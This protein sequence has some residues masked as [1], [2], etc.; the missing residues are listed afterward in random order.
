[1]NHFAFIPAMPSAQNVSSRLN[2]LLEQRIN[3]LTLSMNLRTARS[4]SERALQVISDQYKKYNTTN[5][6]NQKT[7]FKIHLVKTDS[8]FIATILAEFAKIEILTEK[9][10]NEHRSDARDHLSHKPTGSHNDELNASIIHLGNIKDQNKEK[11]FRKS[12]FYQTVVHESLHSKGGLPDN[13]SYSIDWLNEAITERLTT[14][15]IQKSPELLKLI[16]NKWSEAYHGDTAI[17]QYL[18]DFVGKDVVYAAFFSRSMNPIINELKALGFDSGRIK[19][20]FTIAA[21]TFDSGTHD[22]IDFSN[23]MKHLEGVAAPK[24]E[25]RRKLAELV[26]VAREA[27]NATN[28]YLSPVRDALGLPRRE[29]RVRLEE[30]VRSEYKESYE[31]A[32]FGSIRHAVQSSGGFREENL[33]WLNGA[34]TARISDSIMRQYFHSEYDSIGKNELKRSWFLNKTAEHLANLAGERAMERA[35]LSSDAS[36]LKEKLF[37][38]KLSEEEVDEL[39]R[40]GSEANSKEGESKLISYLKQ[41]RRRQRERSFTYDEE[42]ETALNKEGWK[43]VY[44][45]A[46]QAIPEALSRI[47]KEVK[48]EDI[49]DQI[50]E[51]M[52]IEEDDI[53][54]NSMAALHDHLA[55]S[56]NGSSRFLAKLFLEAAQAHI[57][58]ETGSVSPQAVAELAEDLSEAFSDT[59]LA[60]PTLPQMLSMLGKEILYSHSQAVPLGEFLGARNSRFAA[61]A[62]GMAAQC[63]ALEKTVPEAKEYALKAAAI[64][65]LAGITDVEGFSKLMHAADM[66]IH[67]CNRPSCERNEDMVEAILIV[68]AKVGPD[69]E[70][71]AAEIDKRVYEQARQAFAPAKKPGYTDVSLYADIHYPERTNPVEAIETVSEKLGLIYPG[72]AITFSGM[73]GFSIYSNSLGHV[74]P[75]PP[76]HADGGSIAKF[77]AYAGASNTQRMKAVFPGL[78]QK[79]GLENGTNPFRDGALVAEAKKQLRIADHNTDFE[80]FAA[81]FDDYKN[82]GPKGIKFDMHSER[83]GGFLSPEDILRLK[84]ALCLEH[85]CLF[86][87]LVSEFPDLAFAFKVFR[88]ENWAHVPHVSAGVFIENNDANNGLLARI[89]EKHHASMVPHY[90]FELDRDYRKDMLRKIGM[91]YDPGSRLVLLD[92]SF[93]VIGAQ[94]QHIE[95]ITSAEELLSAY[96]VDKGSDAYKRGSIGLALA[97]FITALKINPAD[98]LARSHLIAYYSD[99]EYDPAKILDL[100]KDYSNIVNTEDLVSRS[101][102]FI[103]QG[104]IGEAVDALLHAIQMSEHAA[105]ARFLMVSIMKE[106]AQGSK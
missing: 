54:R 59:Y 16:N 81:L 75:N 28:A 76:G 51:K 48:I 103:T 29:M 47:G 58:L 32:R 26:P 24:R 19:K 11:G 94:Y 60:K 57:V 97:D 90:R 68:K 42:F 31:T 84:Y 69:S 105:K 7:A 38:A 18:I 77:S 96:F 66:A 87:E 64:Y 52:L 89:S 80:R 102:V 3:V 55:S 43:A 14:E 44:G 45:G 56:Y 37:D 104:K 33:A 63:A 98:Q 67:S 22:F 34:I 99:I 100:S 46:G 65:G 4:I 30:I 85:T 39:F 21:S 106:L 91:N 70:K 78:V 50:A 40:L 49:A 72:S 2:V 83:Q 53:P 62:A 8:E 27:M 82:G 88:N 79:H 71:I 13:A 92:F 15:I 17:A 95:P 6:E 25:E 41:L 5:S 36:L 86:L 10:K 101:A 9:R 61:D 35:F 23:Y 20:I 73:N 74:I 1:M 93:S 12:C